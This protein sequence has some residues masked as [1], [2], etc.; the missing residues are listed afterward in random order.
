MSGTWLLTGDNRAV[1]AK[2]PAAS[3]H[4]V[5]TSPPYWALR[6]YGLP[7]SV[8]GGDGSCVDHTWGE[9]IDYHDVREE[10]VHGKTRTGDRHYG[11][12]ET[13]RFDGNHQKHIAGAVCTKCGAWHG[14]LGLEPDPDCGLAGS[15]H[16]CG[17]CYVCHMVEVFAAVVRVLRPDGT[18]WLNLGDSYFA[19]GSTTKQANDTRNY[20]AVSTLQSFHTEGSCERPIKPRTHE[21]LKTKDLI[22]IPWRVALALQRA[23]WYL[24]FSIPW[25]RRNPMPSSVRDR[26][27][28]GMEYVFLLAHPESKGRYF[29]DVDAVR[30]ASTM[31]PQRRGKPHAKRTAVEALGP[32]HP[33]Q[34]FSTSEVR[35]EPG[36]DAPGGMR[37]RRDTDWWFESL[38]NILEGGSGMVTDE[39]GDPLAL[40][41]TTKPL[42]AAHF[43]AFPLDLVE[44]M[45]RAGTSEHGVCSNCKAPWVRVTGRECAGCGAMVPTQG[46]KCA[47]CGH[48]NDW[49]ASRFAPASEEGAAFAATDYSTPGRGTPRKTGSMGESKTQAV[50]WAPSCQ[51]S[52]ISHTPCGISPAAVLD[53]FSGAGT[54]VLVAKRLGRV[55][56]GIDLNPEYTKLA[57]GRMEGA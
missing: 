16:G 4:C 40:V 42:K 48:V 20:R 28:L 17:Q 14:C 9:R 53:P 30:V 19:G 22:G 41:V 50:G 44:P 54:T 8:W 43:A 38:R 47:D 57:Q 25:V 46:K 12:D 1:L 3:V 29:Y 21:V 37:N 39:V 23:G 35:D 52:E 5:V 7:P 27:N 32:G 56:I 24:R 36:V 2:L 26:P 13:R 31:K 34:R 6:D 18:L 55:G 10:T 45:I 33:P 51:C 15:E 49:K 11:E